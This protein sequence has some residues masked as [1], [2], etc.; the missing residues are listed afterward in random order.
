M[1]DSMHRVKAAQHCLPR[2]FREREFGSL[3][4]IRLGQGMEAASRSSDS[5]LRESQVIEQTCC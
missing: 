5:R 3:E 4:V 2:H 1:L